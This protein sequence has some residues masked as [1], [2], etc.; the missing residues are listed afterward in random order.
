MEEV[1]VL[2]ID[3]DK[4][5]NEKTCGFGLEWG[6]SQVRPTPSLLSSSSALLPSFQRR[7]TSVAAGTNH[8][9]VVVSSGEVLVWGRGTEGQLG[10]GPSIQSLATPMLVD[11]GGRRVVAAACG[12]V[13]TS[14]L[15]IHDETS[16]LGCLTFG[17]G[18]C[19]ALGVGSD[20]TSSDR[21]VEVML[22]S[23]PLYLKNLLRDPL[24]EDEKEEE[25]EEKEDVRDVENTETGSELPTVSFINVSC[26]FA[27]MAAIVEVISPSVGFCRFLLFT[28]GWNKRGQLGV[29]ST[30]NE[31]APRH[32][33]GLRRYD[34]SSIGCGFEMTAAVTTQGDLFV[35][36]QGLEGQLGLGKRRVQCGEPQR[37][38]N[39]HTAG[40]CRTVSC[41]ADHTAVLRRDGL[42]MIW[43]RHAGFRPRF[44]TGEYSSEVASE[45]TSEVTNTAKQ[46]M[47]KKECG[48]RRRKERTIRHSG[49]R[50]MLMCGE[51]SVC[52]HDQEGSVHHWPALNGLNGDDGED[53]PL[54]MSLH[55]RNGIP[56]SCT[57][58]AAGDSWEIYVPSL[59]D[60]CQSL[61]RVQRATMVA[62]DV[63]RMQLQVV[64]E[65]GRT[66]HHY[67]RITITKLLNIRL[68]WMG[69][70]IARNER[71]E[72]RREERGDERGGDMRNMTM[73]V[74]MNVACWDDDDE[75]SKN[76][77]EMES[78]DIS[79]VVSGMI[80]LTK[81]GLWELEVTYKNEK[82]EKRHVGDSPIMLTVMP[83]PMCPKKCL[84]SP[85]QTTKNRTE[86]RTEKEDAISLQWE[87]RSQI[88]I[89]AGQE[90]L[91]DLL[92]RDE[93]ENLVNVGGMSISIDY[94]AEK[95]SQTNDDGGN[96]NG[97]A[98]NGSML[99][100]GD[101]TYTGSIKL[102]I[103]G[104]YRV[105]A[106]RKMTT[107]TTTLSCSSS[108][109]STGGRSAVS[110]RRTTKQKSSITMRERAA[111][112][113][114]RKRDKDKVRQFRKKHCSTPLSSSHSPSHSSLCSSKCIS[115]LSYELT[116]G[117]VDGCHAM[118]DNDEVCGFPV[119]LDVVPSAGDASCIVVAEEVERTMTIGM[120]STIKLLL[121]DIYGNDTKE[122]ETEHF[123]CFVQSL[124]SHLQRELIVPVTIRRLTN[125]LETDSS[126]LQTDTTA[127][128]NNIN[129]TNNT[130]NN[131]N[132]TNNTD[133][134]DNTDNT[135]TKS[136]IPPPPPVLNAYELTYAP[137]LRG[138][139]SVECTLRNVPVT[140]SPWYVRV[141][142]NNASS[143][144]VGTTQRGPRTSWNSQSNK[145]GGS[146]SSESS[147]MT[148]SKRTRSN[149]NSSFIQQKHK[150]ERRPQTA[151]LRRRCKGDG[152]SNPLS[153]T[154]KGPKP[155]PPPEIA[156]SA[157][158][159]SLS[160]HAIH[161]HSSKMSNKLVKKKNKQRPSTA[162][163][164]SR[165]RV[166]KA[167]ASSK[168]NQFATK[169]TPKTTRPRSIS[170]QK[171]TS[172]SKMSSH[173]LA[174]CQARNINPLA[175]KKKEPVLVNR[176]GA[177]S[178]IRPGSSLGIRSRRTQTN[179]RK[180]TLAAATLGLLP[181][182][183][184]PTPSTVKQPKASTSKENSMRSPRNYD[185]SNSQY[186]KKHRPFTS[187]PHRRP[188]GRVSRR[189]TKH[190]PTNIHVAVKQSLFGQDEMF[191]GGSG[192]RGRGPCC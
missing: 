136:S 140:G 33:V 152:N 133:N 73:G 192:V 185:P 149:R 167:K 188:G 128:T 175:L 49:Q 47:Q 64:D 168:R 95:K 110:E 72:E 59:P 88:Q 135:N 124:S 138:A 170:F 74:G 144:S 153:P 139:F 100:H 189:I 3:V 115:P 179:N 118:D 171:Q 24:N 180:D 18:L 106:L 159:S 90:Q 20:T 129:N 11:V 96:G 66:V 164:S 61:L 71:G 127:N 181:A 52:I 4:H 13:H 45:V 32:V 145:S 42:V 191:R 183:I 97:V 186:C 35:F 62:G 15:F 1:L 156:F 17:A 113:V 19:G 107:D 6:A 102:D 8:A 126:H 89:L 2:E 146:R 166:L 103:A 137:H 55:H 92:T 105:F 50:W 14:L 151:M 39:R 178:K 37:H 157:A 177:S 21:P 67:D 28:W 182:S 57:C 23:D 78:A 190:G 68:R 165:Q 101:G 94:L 142:E 54:Q 83:G 79:A 116:H 75:E 93:Y 26:G 29:G 148:T 162:S 22:T 56:L 141:T 43:G 46:K 134:T 30:E 104:T 125:P 16:A 5:C 109:P 9:V 48:E 10:L 27:H 44:V 81:S 143:L 114:R 70:D 119:K 87:R 120:T 40:V 121:R 184:L 12:Y 63:V 38:L 99:D 123:V 172:S 150:L 108:R 155:L 34:V 53:S 76:E 132:N 176:G 160:N 51:H 117:I 60:F 122:D 174:L 187:P 111:R 84:W 131:T 82:G 91:F 169:K 41:G 147:K 80:S 130:T 77:D 65:R 112:Q 161:H 69:G 85:Q 154:S 36:G 31:F 173:M 25:E 86:N 163:S 7:I 58:F 98:T 158:G